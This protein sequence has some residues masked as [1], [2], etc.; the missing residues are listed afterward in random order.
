MNFNPQIITI[1]LGFKTYSTNKIHKNNSKNNK[2]EGW[3]ENILS[4]I[5]KLY[6]M[7]YNCF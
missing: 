4:K 1:Y 7:Q 2:S 5:P 6:I 3:N